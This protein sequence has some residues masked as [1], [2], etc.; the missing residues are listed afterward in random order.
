M[1]SASATFSPI[2]SA[3]M[4]GWAW[5]RSG[6][7]HARPDI[8][9]TLEVDFLEAANAA[10]RTRDH[11]GRRRARSHCPGGRHRTARS[12]DCRAK[13]ARRGRGSEPG[14]ALVEI[15]RAGRITQFKRAG[16]DITLELPIAIDEAVLGAKVEVPTVSGRVQLTIPKGTSSGR[17]FRLKGKGVATA[18]PATP[19][20]SS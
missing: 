5:H 4:R 13:V 7:P 18:P 17:V 2:C 16:D 6:L 9:Y 11:A 10:P 3:A 8:R 20:T 19:A 12:C 15:K 1:T 14:D